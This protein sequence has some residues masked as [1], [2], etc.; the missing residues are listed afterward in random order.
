VEEIAPTEAD[1]ANQA[2]SLQML[3]MLTRGVVGQLA[4]N[5]A[6]NGLKELVKTAEVTQKRDRV[7]VTGTV[8]PASLANLAVTTHDS[9]QTQ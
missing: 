3:V 9:A 5:P 6:N 2:A 7:V 1:A 4:S 8:S